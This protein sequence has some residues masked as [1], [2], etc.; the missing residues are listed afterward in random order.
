MWTKRGGANKKLKVKLSEGIKYYLGLF[1]LSLCGYAIFLGVR[2]T[3]ISPFLPPKNM[4]K[5]MVYLKN[6]EVGG[7][8]RLNV[9]GGDYIKFTPLS[10]DESVYWVEDLPSAD[11]AKG[12]K[13]PKIILIRGGANERLADMRTYRFFSYGTA[14]GGEIWQYKPKSRELIKRVDPSDR[15]FGY[16]NEHMDFIYPLE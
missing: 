3:I 5:N 12:E 8:E 14:T 4:T 15:F 13:I 7:I 10:D 16:E 2:E 1:M 9:Y 6:V 11:Y